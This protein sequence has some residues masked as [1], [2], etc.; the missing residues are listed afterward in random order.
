MRLSVSAPEIGARVEH[1]AGKRVSWRGSMTAIPIS[2]FSICSAARERA[3][4]R[5]RLA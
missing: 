2:A 3:G 1:R 4:T 5:L